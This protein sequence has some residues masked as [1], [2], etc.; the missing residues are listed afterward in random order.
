MQA[1]AAVH[2]GV[3]SSQDAARLGA[4]DGDIRALMRSGLWTRPRRAVY[5]DPTFEPRAAERQHVLDAASL[6]A[7]CGP[8]TVLSH[9]S[10]ARLLEMPQPAGRWPQGVSIT[11]P[12]GAHGNAP[13]GATV[14]VAAWDPGDVVVVEGVAVLGGARMV[15]D[16]AAVLPGPDALAIADAALRRQLTTLDELSTERLRRAAHPRSPAFG[17]VVSRADGLSE[18]WFESASRWWILEAGLPRPVLQHELRAGGRTARVDML[19]DGLGTVGEADGA[20]KYAGVDGPQALVE[21]KL[22]EEWIRDCFGLEVVRWMPPDI[23]SA[24]ARSAW[25]ERVRAAFRR[26]A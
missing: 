4:G 20:L 26:A 24:R 10:A 3:I 12:P 14:H 22:R 16:C 18:S 8:A 23:R 1:H 5:A 15:L 2:G 17:R 9:T 6:L 7:A 13:R 19:F 11:R 25:L 21:E